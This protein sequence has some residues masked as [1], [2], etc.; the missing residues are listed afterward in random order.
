MEDTIC[1]VATSLGVGA[2]SIIKV[3]GTEAINIVSKI[4]SNKSLINSKS[5]MIHYGFIMEDNLKT[6]EVLVSVMLSPKSYTTENVVE[7]NCHGG[8]SSTN[9]VLELLINN[10]CRLAEP[11]E[12]TKRAFLNGRIDLI[13]AEAVG[14]LINAKT[15]SERQMF[16]NQIEGKVSKR[17]SS[18]REDLL[19][20]M[21]NIEVNIDY[22]EYEDAVLITNNMIKEKINKIKLQI[23]ELLED[24]RNGKIIKNGINMVILGKP[25]VGK[26]SIL[27]HLLNENKAIVTSLAGTTRDIVEGDIILN[28]IKLHVIDTAGIRKTDNIVEQIGVEKSLDQIKDADLIIYVIDSQNQIDVEELKIIEQS[29]EKVILFINKSDLNP[30]KLNIVCEDYKI[31][32]GNTISESGLDLLKNEIINRFNLDKIETKDLTYLSNVREITELQ[33]CLK[34]IDDIEHGIKNNMPSDIIEIDIKK[35]WDVL[36]NI[37]GQTYQD[38]LLDNLFSKFCLGK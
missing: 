36:G 25:N 22:P 7:I 3:S 10:G 15:E 8:V 37:I 38:E 30:N 12:F 26:S 2:V 28:G 31:V 23:Q 14:D 29:K 24:S 27:N 19:N 32:Y 9:K 5:H 20:L 11:G 1:A 18:L 35:C 21:S 6:D 13:E 17:I 16:M 33:S 34:I 4:F